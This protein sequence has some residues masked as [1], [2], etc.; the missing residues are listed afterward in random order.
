MLDHLLDRRQKYLVVLFVTTKSHD[1]N[2]KI[3]C[4]QNCKACMFIS[5]CRQLMSHSSKYC[6][7]LRVSF[8]A[9]ATLVL[10]RWRIYLSN[11]AVYDILKSKTL[12]SVRS[13][14]VYFQFLRKSHFLCHTEGVSKWVSPY[15]LD[16]W[17]FSVRSIV[18]C[19]CV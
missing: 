12:E 17:Y 10:H 13:F 15:S 2:V 8:G 18:L 3:E 11:E 1:C 7:L 19:E 16:N 4:R 14:A 5:T 9:T 6:I